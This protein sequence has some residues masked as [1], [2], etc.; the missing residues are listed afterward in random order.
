MTTRR[1]DINRKNAR[2]PRVLPALR[3]AIAEMAVF[4]LTRVAAAEAS[5]MSDSALR[6]ALR[7]PHVKA[8]YRQCVRDVRSGAYF[9][10][11]LNMERLAETADSERVQL[12]ANQWL[13]GVGGL[14]PMKMTTNLAIL[15][16]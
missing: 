15:R 6:K 5:G 2:K 12:K 13:V 11:Y 7:K 3:C 14:A 9:R 16:S 4:G 8:L 1:S 10:A